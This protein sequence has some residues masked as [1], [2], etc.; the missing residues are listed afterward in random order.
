MLK[1][2]IV[3]DEPLARDELTYILQRTKRMKVI[4]EAESL[5]DAMLG[6]RQTK[7]DVVFLDIQLSEESG[8]EL[9]QQ[10]QGLD[11]RPEIVFATAYDEH[12]LKAFELNAID[13]I[14][15]PYDE[16]RIQQSVDKLVRLQEGRGQRQPTAPL[17]SSA[18]GRTGKLAITV[19]ERIILVAVSSILYL[20]SEEGKTLLVTEDQTYRVTEPL[21]AFEQ[22]LQG[23]PI[24]RVH[25]AY[26]VHIDGISEIQP[27]FHSTCTLI[28]KNGSKV[29]VSRTHLKEL[30]QLIG[31]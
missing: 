7:P 9:A 23:T 3:E 12:A 19:E 15:K 22:K 6:I 11:W 14:L 18:P 26:L 4:G 24:I 17:H 27:W 28:M 16:D 8:L 30:K 5:E 13:Y 2:F 31:L 1:A 20:A 25:R 29:P 10:L 21:V